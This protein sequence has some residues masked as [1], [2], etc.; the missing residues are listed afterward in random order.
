MHWY[1]DVLKKY[2]DFKGRS[3]RKEYWI[4]ALFTLII[5]LVLDMVS[6]AL[7]ASLQMEEAI[8]GPSF[9]PWERKWRFQKLRSC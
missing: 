8:R 4:F 5:S 9:W 1:L 3:R 7:T 2:A 6:G